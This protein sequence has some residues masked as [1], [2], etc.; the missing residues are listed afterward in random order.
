M[1]LVL[2][3]ALAC[4]PAVSQIISQSVLGPPPERITVDKNNVDV[5]SGSVVLSAPGLSIGSDSYG[6]TLTQ[7]YSSAAGW[8]DSFTGVLNFQMWG[9]G[10]DHSAYSAS[11][12]GQS[13]S[14]GSGID[15]SMTGAVLQPIDFTNYQVIT[16]DGTVITYGN[17]AN[18]V[19]C[20]GEGPAAFCNGSLHATRVEY[21][22]GVVV[23][24]HYRAYSATSAFNAQI[25]IQSVTSNTGYQVK[26]VYQSDA[27]PATYAALSQALTRVSAVAVNN[28][29]EYCDP[30]ADTC[31]LSGNWPTVTYANSTGTHT[32]TDPLGRSTV[33]TYSPTSFRVRTAG[34]LTDNVQYTLAAFTD[35]YGNLV[36]RVTSAAIGGSTWSYSY[37][38]AQASAL[39]TTV[40][41]PQGGQTVYNS[42]RYEFADA[43]SSTWSAWALVSMKNPLNRITSFSYPCGPAYGVLN[44]QSYVAT[45]PEGIVSTPVCDS[46][47]NVTSTTTQAKPGSG[48]QAIGTSATFPTAAFP[49]SCANYKTCNKP[50]ATVD[51]RGAQT[52]YA[53]DP[54]HGGVLTQTLPADISGARPQ[55]R[56][57]YQQFNAYVKNA[58]GTLVSATGS[59]WLPTRISECRT[60]S[61]SGPACGAGP[62]DEVVTTFEYAGARF[63]LIGTTRFPGMGTT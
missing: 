34:S 54:A 50:T 12:G 25:R 48:F 45:S 2:V 49:V 43:Y 1:W 21:P 32:F 16:R 10:Y 11:W 29:V 63:P 33:Y 62:A 60:S 51:G 39:T 3:G 44:T 24:P 42:T 7:F 58:S 5:T 37:S 19:Y 17:V 30:D 18:M 41:D 38:P 13:W 40:T 22:N 8:H 6:L 52:E 57:Q 56:Y 36:S 55:K 46:R 27:V 4:N 20:A 26:F 59:I 47:G 35:Y 14:F 31:S 53:Y 28:A 9:W 23:T 15:H 61:Y